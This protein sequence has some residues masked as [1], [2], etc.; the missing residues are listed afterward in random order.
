MKRISLIICALICI[1]SLTA[2]GNSASNNNTNNSQ[3]QSQATT[4]P[5][6]TEATKSP[7][8]LEAEKE[9]IKKAEE[10]RKKKLNEKLSSLRK[11]ADEVSGNTW[12][13]DVNS[14]KYTNANDFQL[15]LGEVNGQFWPR[16]RIQFCAENWLFIESYIISVDG[17]NYNFN[18]SYDDI[19][20]DNDNGIVW[21]WYDFYPTNSNLKMMQ[22]VVDSEKTILRHQGDIYYEDRIIS[23]QEKQS[24][25]NILDI[26]N[27]LSESEKWKQ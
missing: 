13:Y 12:Y 20:R 7:E 27:M 18:P 17:T 15:Y 23:N 6:V 5:T 3:I 4:P 14:E 10:E 21:E 19:K 26:Y 24:I 11:V 1:T 22:E 25:K 2:C 16:V 9:E 8:E